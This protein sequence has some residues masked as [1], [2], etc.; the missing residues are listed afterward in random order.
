MVMVS[1][2]DLPATILAPAA[3]PEP[4]ASRSSGAS[5][6]IVLKAVG[7]SMAGYVSGYGLRLVSSLIMTRLLVPEMFGVMAVATVV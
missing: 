7:W 2:R 6:Q 4:L 5:R 3:D 1:S